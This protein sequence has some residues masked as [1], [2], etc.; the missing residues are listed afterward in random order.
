MD[1]GCKDTFVPSK[2]QENKTFKDNEQKTMDKMIYSSGVKSDKCKNILTK[3]ACASYTP[4]CSRGDEEK[5]K[6]LCRSECVDLIDDCP[7]AFSVS[8]VAS[9]CAEPA[10]GHSDSGFCELTRWPSARHWDGGEELRELVT[11]FASQLKNVD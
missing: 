7:E 4:P 1:A 2:T 3:L 10:E 8:E 5:K 11:V 9:Y 6:T